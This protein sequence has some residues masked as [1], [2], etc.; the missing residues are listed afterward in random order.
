M[1][2][3]IQTETEFL[4]AKIKMMTV[5]VFLTPPNLLIQM[6]TASPMNMKARKKR[7]KPKHFSPIMA[8]F[9][10]L[11]PKVEASSNRKA[12]KKFYIS[13]YLL[14]DTK[15]ILQPSKQDLNIDI[16]RDY[17][18]STNSNQLNNICRTINSSP[19]KIRRNKKN[20]EIQAGIFWWTRN[21]QLKSFP[22]TMLKKWLQNEME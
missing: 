13:S 22:R 19:K 8:Y 14:L 7:R 17:F 4:T 9:S 12:R 20:R 11:L 15:I 5:M 18:K 21:K 3:L 1:K 10:T 6:A 2:P 16:V